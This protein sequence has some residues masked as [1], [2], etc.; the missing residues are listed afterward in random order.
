MGDD[1]L[2]LG[3]LVRVTGELKTIPGTWNYMPGWPGRRDMINEQ[4]RRTFNPHADQI[5]MGS[6][7][8]G[9]EDVKLMG[10]SV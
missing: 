6:E 7:I 3:A 2:E 9:I 5:G 8:N 10:Q 4:S 1:E